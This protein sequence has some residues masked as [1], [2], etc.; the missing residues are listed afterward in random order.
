M[1]EFQR[2]VKR[3]LEIVHAKLARIEN[4][5]RID[6]ALDVQNIGAIMAN[7]DALTTEVGEISDTV[8][9]AIALIAGLRQQIIDAGTDPTKLAD[10][11]AQLDAKQQAL[12]EAVAT[13]GGSTGGV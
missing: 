1:S 4:T 8:D 3:S 9:S 6:M 10:L 5:L 12:A 11:V 7:L 2:Y 13:P